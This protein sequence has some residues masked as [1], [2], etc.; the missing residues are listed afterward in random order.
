MFPTV[1]DVLRSQRPDARIT[2]FHH[3]GGFADLVERGVPNVIEH[4][5]TAT[6]TMDEL[7]SHR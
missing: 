7:I 1:F 6:K 3:W 4:H 2:V 5:G